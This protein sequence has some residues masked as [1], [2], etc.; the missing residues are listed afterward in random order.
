VSVL[1]HSLDQA[2]TYERLD[3]SGM[4]H[5]IAGLPEQ[6]R[7]AWDA[8]RRWPLPPAFTKPSRVVV[9][10]MGGSAIG[11]DMIAT[12]SARSSTVPIQIVRGY[13]MPATDEH[14]LVVASSFSGDTEETLETFNTALERPGMHLALTSGGRLG[15]L[16]GSL[17]Y[18]L[19]KYDF[20]G[21][22]RSALGWG[23][24]PLLALLH[25]LGA[26]DVDEAAVDSTI[27]ELGQAATDWGIDRPC[28]ENAAKLIATALHGRVPLIVGTDFFEVVARRWAGQV[29]ENAKQWAFHV[30][31]PEANHNLIVG[32]ASPPAAREAL[33]VL[34][35]DSAILHERNRLRVRMTGEALDRAGISHDELLIGGADPLD[36]MLRASYLGD[37]VSLYLGM[38]NEVDPTPV[39]P[40]SDLKLD[41]ARHGHG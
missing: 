9:L 30:A 15:R 35:L 41:M 4:R 36:A 1:D 38:L 14:T 20:Q 33:H 21:Q 31:L 22:P 17:G 19:L 13:T 39:T 7:Q 40:I 32:F 12:L 11:G 29:N 25:R 5:L 2:E 8:G 6:S 18:A 24:F 16:A 27:H 37:W 23:V 26:I 28:D 10:G 3:L 34:F